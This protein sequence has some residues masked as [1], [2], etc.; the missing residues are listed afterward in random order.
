MTRL[1]ESEEDIRYQTERGIEE[2]DPAE[3]QWDRIGADAVGRV[4]V[5]EPDV[6][7]EPVP[8]QEPALDGVGTGQGEQ[9]E[10]S[11]SLLVQVL[12]S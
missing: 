2:R 5:E 12:G 11:R 3:R 7:E 1:L 4:V 8:S 6:G 9:G 10:Q